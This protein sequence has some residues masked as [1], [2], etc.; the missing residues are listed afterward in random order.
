MELNIL[1]FPDVAKTGLLTALMDQSHHSKKGMATFLW[2][3]KI[4]DCMTGDQLVSQSMS[5]QNWTSGLEDSQKYNC[6]HFEDG[7]CLWVVTDLVS[8]CR[9]TILKLNAQFVIIVIISQPSTTFLLM[10]L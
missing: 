4:G 2:L 3:W 1:T 7:N 5:L 10:G 8:I 9:G 6:K